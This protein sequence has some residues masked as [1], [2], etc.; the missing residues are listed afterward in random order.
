MVQQG[1]LSNLLS[2]A[3]YLTAGAYAGG[4]LVMSRPVEKFS[5]HGAWQ[6]G[7][8]GLGVLTQK[9]VLQYAGQFSHG[10]PHGLGV[11]FQAGQ[12]YYAG[13]FVSS[14][15]TA[16]ELE[17][18]NHFYTGEIDDG[19]PTGLGLLQ[20][21]AIEFTGEVAEGRP[22]AGMWKYLDGAV[23]CGSSR[24]SD[25]WM[26][27]VTYTS[28]NRYA[29]EFEP[30]THTPQGYGALKAGPLLLIGTFANGNIAGPGGLRR[31]GGRV[32]MGIW[33]STLFFEDLGRAQ[34]GRNDNPFNQEI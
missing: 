21:D 32:S 13:K 31:P 28:G 29:G 10:E 25:R 18:D 16:G 5:Y 4:T 12:P 15:P 2:A 34:F 30:G 19:A 22:Q 24:F 9:N 8:H 11:I 23:S 6:G 20:Y 33:E 26:G 27:Q 14:Q 1:G 3:Q 17:L 7:P